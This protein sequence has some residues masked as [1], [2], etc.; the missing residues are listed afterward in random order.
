MHDAGG[1][2]AAAYSRRAADMGFLI[3]FRRDENGRWV[4]DGRRTFWRNLQVLA[5]LFVIAGFYNL[6]DHFIK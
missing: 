5:A 6:I 1:D 4:L 2:M 3:C